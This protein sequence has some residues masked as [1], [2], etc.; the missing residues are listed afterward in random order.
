M[1]GVRLASGDGRQTARDGLGMRLGADRARYAPSPAPWRH[2]QPV[3]HTVDRAAGSDGGVEGGCGSD[4]RATGGVLECG[5]QR[6]RG[7]QL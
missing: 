1:V 3:A 6:G 5:E 2:S 4:D 7:A